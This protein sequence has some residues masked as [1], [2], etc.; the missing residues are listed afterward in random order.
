[1]SYFFSTYVIFEVMRGNPSYE[2]YKDF[3]LIVSVLNL[4]EL[5]GTVLRELGEEKANEFY[6]KF[7]FQVVEITPEVI[8]EAVK[9]RCKNRKEDVSLPD[10]VGYLLAKKH[11]LKFLTGDKFFENKDNVEFVK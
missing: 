1:M 9:F 3:P 10:A 2:K 7:V 5:Y 4:A 8:I 11:K 6:G